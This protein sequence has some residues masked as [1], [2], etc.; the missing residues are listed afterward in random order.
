MQENRILNKKSTSQ[1]GTHKFKTIPPIV[2]N[3]LIEA[4]NLERV[5]KER[6]EKKQWKKPIP[7]NPFLLNLN[8]IARTL[9]F[10]EYLDFSNSIKNNS[11]KFVDP[12]LGFGLKQHNL[13]LK[14]IDDGVKIICNEEENNIIESVFSDILRS[15]VTDKSFHSLCQKLKDEEIPYFFQFKQEEHQELESRNNEDESKSKIKN[16]SKNKKKENAKKF[17]N[18]QNIKT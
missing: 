10:E 13:T 5:R 7:P 6:A 8:V 4:S 1:L 9:V 15:L 12:I 16:S 2:K 14:E 3:S 17:D 18:T 11:T